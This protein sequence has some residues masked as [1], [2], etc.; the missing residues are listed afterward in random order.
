M[1]YV[2]PISSAIMALV[3]VVYFQLFF[4]QYKRNNRP[5]LVIH[6]AQDEMPDALCLLVNM[7]EQPVHVLCVQAIAYPRNGTPKSFTVTE[8]ERVNPAQ[9]D[10]QQV[11]RQGPLQP[12]GYLVLGSFRNIVLGRQSSEEHSGYLLEDFERLE[13]RAAVIHGPSKFPV[14]ARR[15]FYFHHQDGTRVYPQN[16]HT[17]QLIRRQDLRT[18][19]TWVEDE[20][21]PKRTG[22]Q[23]SDYSE[24][25]H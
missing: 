5:Y 16:I 6:H 22:G 24:Q 19:R 20:L 21:N 7:G 12:G 18:V 15:L 14:G 8:Y 4:L 23:E 1:E 17:E 10:I 2:A 9:K 3:W 25:A 11:L 13:I